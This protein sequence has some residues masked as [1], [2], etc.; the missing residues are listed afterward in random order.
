V[1]MRA[2]MAHNGWTAGRVRGHRWIAAEGPETTDPAEL[3]YLMTGH[4][5]LLLALH[6]E[7]RAHDYFVA[8]AGSSRDEETAQLAARLAEEEVDHLN[9]VRDWLQRYPATGSGRDSDDDPAMAQ[10]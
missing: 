9:W 4:Q 10:D 1:E 7:Q 6:N 5:A 3:H 8:I 2:L